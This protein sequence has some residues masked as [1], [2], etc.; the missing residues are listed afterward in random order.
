MKNSDLKSYLF[1]SIRSVADEKSAAYVA[2]PL[3]TGLEYYVLMSKGKEDIAKNIRIK[4][5]QKMNLFISIL[6]KKLKYPVIDPS[7]LVVND[8]SSLEIGNFFIE[9][10]GIFAKEVWFMDDW[11]FSR[12]ATKEFQFCLAN[13]ITCIDERGNAITAKEAEQLIGDAIAKLD[14]LGLDSSRFNA[15]LDGIRDRKFVS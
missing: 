5:E 14:S 12:G 3:A 15:R 8:W 13:S 1:A 9:I 7:Q 4:N 11:Q 2:G 10:I 6:R